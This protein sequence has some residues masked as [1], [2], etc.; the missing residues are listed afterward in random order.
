MFARSVPD[1]EMQFYK[2]R[3]V[4]PPKVRRK[5]IKSKLLRMVRLSVA[6]LEDTWQRLY[7]TS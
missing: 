7:A 4:E 3:Q 1:S 5:A 6:E 2:L